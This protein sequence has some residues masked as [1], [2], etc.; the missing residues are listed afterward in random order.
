MLQFEVRPNNETH[1][2]SDEAVCDVVGYEPELRSQVR[3]F[4]AE[5]P[6]LGYRRRTRDEPTNAS[7]PTLSS[8][9]VASEFAERRTDPG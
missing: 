4:L 9:C 8:D 5:E 7:S 3:A 6:L 2:A 1:I